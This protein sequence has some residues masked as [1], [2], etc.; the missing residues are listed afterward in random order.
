MYRELYDKKH[1]VY[2]LIVDA[3]KRK[4][5]KK[6]SRF[7]GEY[8]GGILCRECDN[9]LLGSLEDYGSKFLYGGKFKKGEELVMK[10]FITQEGLRFT[11]IQ[12]ISYKKLKLFLLSVLWRC[13]ISNRD[14]F[15]EISLEEHEETFRS[16]IYNNNSYLWNQFPVFIMTYLSD[17]Q[18]PKDLIA[19]PQKRTTADGIEVFVLIISGFI[20]S[21]FLPSPNGNYPN[22]VN[23]G[24]LKEDGSIKILHIPEGHGKDMINSFCGFVL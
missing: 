6:W 9:K 15:N 3:A 10:N 24:A 19:H 13:S 4:L 2:S 7:T 11:E 22:Y 23:E 5:V 20:Y 17:N 1:R 18:L 16:M 21:F 12:N 14:G 8:Q